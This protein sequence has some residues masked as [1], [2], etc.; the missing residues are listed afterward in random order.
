MRPS[1]GT[2]RLLIVD[3]DLIVRTLF[4][5][6]LKATGFACNADGDGPERMIA[7]IVRDIEVG[8]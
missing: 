5:E 3:G 1:R 4:V 8:E 6:T 2:S 7:M